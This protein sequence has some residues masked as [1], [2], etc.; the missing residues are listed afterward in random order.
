MALLNKSRLAAI[1][2]GSFAALWAM[3]LFFGIPFLYGKKVEALVG[4]PLATVRGQLGP[5]TREWESANFCCDPGFPCDPAKLS[6][7]PVQMYSDG[8]QAWYLYFDRAAL[9]AQL[10]LVRPGGIPDAGQTRLPLR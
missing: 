6:G 1:V 3:A 5:P 4:H 8:S 10:E 2:L 9:L 7:G